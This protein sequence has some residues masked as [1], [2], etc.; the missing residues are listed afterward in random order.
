MLVFS[1]SKLVLITPP[2]NASTSLHAGLSELP[3]VRWIEGPFPNAV[4]PPMISRHSTFIPEE[5]RDFQRVVVV[6]HPYRRAASLYRHW[7][8]FQTYTGSF[9]EFVSEVLLYPSQNP[10]A[11]NQAAYFGEGAPQFVRLEYLALDFAAYGIDASN[12]PR[13]NEL[14]GG[15][16][17]DDI[18]GIDRETLSRLNYWA[19]DDFRRAGFSMLGHVAPIDPL[20]VCP[21]FRNWKV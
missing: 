11:Q 16:S 7:Q 5:Y 17:I 8:S 14:G 12:L 15:K 9:A 21:A 20:A 1:L 10:F 13:L 3:G 4:G 2:K 6:R 19:M 18:G